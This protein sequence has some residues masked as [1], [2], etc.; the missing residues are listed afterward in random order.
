MLKITRFILLAVALALV[1][2][3]IYIFIYLFIYLFINIILIWPKGISSSHLK[4]KLK[5][6]KVKQQ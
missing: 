3:F 4:K 5:V 1:D 6:I 2:L